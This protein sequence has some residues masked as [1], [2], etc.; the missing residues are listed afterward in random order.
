MFFPKQ[1]RW[2]CKRVKWCTRQGF[3]KA[4]NPAHCS[5]QPFSRKGV[6]FWPAGERRL[7]GG[8][9]GSLLRQCQVR[10]AKKSH[11]NRFFCKKKNFA[12]VCYNFPYPKSWV[13]LIR[14]DTSTSVSVWTSMQTHLNRISPASFWDIP[15]KRI[16][17]QSLCKFT[18]LAQVDRLCRFGR[19]RLQ[20]LD[21][22]SEGL[23]R[24]GGARVGSHQG[25]GGLRCRFQGRFWKTF[26]QFLFFP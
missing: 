21:A 2:R 25:G 11:S 26:L 4:Q 9:G 18:K 17:N 24:A 16:K 8:G 19:G 22:L 10:R 5:I 1:K 15:R 14:L 6:S 23:P 20:L 3:L 13:S 7:R 12:C